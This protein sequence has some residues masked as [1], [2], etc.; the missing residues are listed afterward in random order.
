MIVVIDGVF[1]LVLG[2]VFV[3]EAADLVEATGALLAQRLYV[4]NVLQAK[5]IRTLTVGCDSK[6]R[7]KSHKASER[8]TYLLSMISIIILTT[9]DAHMRR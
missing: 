6:K 4:A 2:V 5:K 3:L 8:Q 7:T 9:D 1:L